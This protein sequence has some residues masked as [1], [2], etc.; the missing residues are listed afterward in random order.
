M[1]SLELA[2]ALSQDRR[3]EVE[4]ALRAKALREA[5]KARRGEERTVAVATPATGLV[6]SLPAV[7][8]AR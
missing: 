2:N 7:T 5:S 4:E 8:R 3:R 6:H 1:L